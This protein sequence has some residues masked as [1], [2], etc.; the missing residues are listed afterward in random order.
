MAKSKTHKQ[1]QNEQMMQFLDKAAM[2]KGVEAVGHVNIMDIVKSLNPNVMEQAFDEVKIQTE[3]SK[4]AAEKFNAPMEAVAK[5]ESSNDVHDR[6]YRQFKQFYNQYKN[7]EKPGKWA[8]TMAKQARGKSPQQH[9]DELFEKW[10]KNPQI[11]KRLMQDPGISEEEK[12]SLFRQEM[13]PEALRELEERGG[14]SP[15]IQLE[16]RIFDHMREQ[17][18]PFEEAPRREGLREMMEQGIKKAGNQA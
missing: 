7:R 9:E 6:N 4:L 8:E 3:A 5:A 15:S 14:A 18:N 16:D 2:D 17:R 10:V 12:D 11:Q 1:K 13:S